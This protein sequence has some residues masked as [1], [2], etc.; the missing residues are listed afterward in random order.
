[1]WLFSGPRLLEV[2]AGLMVPFMWKNLAVHVNMMYILVSAFVNVSSCRIIT[3]PVC[4]G[5]IVFKS[6]HAK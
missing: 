3:L 2:A 5:R 6:K 1:M 4:M